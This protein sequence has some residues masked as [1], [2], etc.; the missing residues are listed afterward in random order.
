MFASILRKCRLC[1]HRV[2]ID[3]TFRVRRGDSQ[4]WACTPCYLELVEKT[5]GYHKAELELGYEV[6]DDHVPDD[7]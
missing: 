4:V 3:S 2:P 6:R 1:G 7:W 5:T